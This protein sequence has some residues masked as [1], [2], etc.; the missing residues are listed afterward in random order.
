[1]NNLRFINM[2]VVFA[3]RSY[4]DNNSRFRFG[5]VLAKKNRILSFGRNRSKTHPKSPS[6]W[7]R[8]HAEMDVIRNAREDPVGADLYIVRVL[9][10]GN[11]AISKPCEDCFEYVRQI[12]IR[13]IYFVNRSGVLECERIR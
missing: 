10:S 12:G 6:P 5:A 4:P 2:A 3:D 9:S 7:K 13:S 11:L 1:M 8:I